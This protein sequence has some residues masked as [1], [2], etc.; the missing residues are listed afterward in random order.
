MFPCAVQWCGARARFVA[1][2]LGRLRAGVGVHVALRV[3]HGEL[4]SRFRPIGARI[5]I[6]FPDGFHDLLRR[7]ALAKQR[8]RARSVADVDDGL[9]RRGA[10][11]R[12]GVEYAVPD[13]EHARLDG[14]ADLAG[15]RIVGENR[16]RS[17]RPGEVGDESRAGTGRCAAPTRNDETMKTAETTTLRMGNSILR[18]AG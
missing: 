4:A 5:G 16:E 18:K 8:D 2:P 10:D 14:A 3:D 1:G 15:L 13:R 11:A 9:R 17:G 6:A 7:D 12:L